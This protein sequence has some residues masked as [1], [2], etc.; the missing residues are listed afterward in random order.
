AAISISGCRPT[1]HNVGTSSS[2]S[3]MAEN[4]GV[5][6]EISLLTHSVPEIPKYTENCHLE[7]LGALGFPCKSGVEFATSSLQ[8]DRHFRIEWLKGNAKAFY[9]IPI[10][11]KVMLKKP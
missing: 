2:E 5:A 8:T 1:S 3:A 4:V 9:H 6:V 10:R 11:S 7:Y